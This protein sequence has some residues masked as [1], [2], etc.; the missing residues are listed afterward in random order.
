VYVI[1]SH[2]RLQKLL[3]LCESMS[4]GDRAQPIMI[5]ICDQDPTYRDYFNVKWPDSWRL[6]IAYGDFSYC[7]EKMNWALERLPNARFY[8]H[9]CDDV[10]LEGKDVLGELAEAAGDWFMAYPNDGIYHTD[11]A[12]F[13][14]SGGKLIRAIGW[15]AHPMFKHNCLDSV[16][17]DIGRTLKIHKPM[18]HLRYVVKHPLLNTAEWDDTY[19]RVESINREAGHLFDTKWR[20][21][22]E[23]KTLIARLN[24]KLDVEG[25]ERV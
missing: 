25:V 9:L 4:E 2:G 19:R 8:G 22:E 10:L 6:K 18:M 21:S 13:P 17:D 16:L 7:G 14:V 24:G 23:R 5:V 20:D 3:Q 12:C 15:W 1:P 11:L